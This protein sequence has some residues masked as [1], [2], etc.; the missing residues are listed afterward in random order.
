MIPSEI[1]KIEKYSDLKKIFLGTF[2]SFNYY[3]KL[4]EDDRFKECN[5]NLINLPISKEI[6]KNCDK[7]Y[8]FGN[9]LCFY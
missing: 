1:T 2:E 5:K 9:H 8:L 7:K 3:D 6:A 4:I